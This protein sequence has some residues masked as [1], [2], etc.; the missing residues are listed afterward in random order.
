MDSV[1]HCIDSDLE[2]HSGR[3][4]LALSAAPT[5]RSVGDCDAHSSSFTPTL[6]S[7]EVDNNR[8][9]ATSRLTMDT[10]RA[11]DRCDGHVNVAFHVCIEQVLFCLYMLRRLC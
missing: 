7:T 3:A 11:A 2:T 8:R 9:I 1:R 6:T 5:S 4:E 10:L